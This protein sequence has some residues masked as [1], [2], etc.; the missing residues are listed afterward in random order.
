MKIWNFS[1]YAALA[2]FVIMV[3]VS[4]VWVDHHKK[5]AARLTIPPV[6]PAS[7]SA[8]GVGA[9]TLNVSRDLVP[10]P[11]AANGH[12]ADSAGFAVSNPAGGPQGAQTINVDGN[13][14]LYVNG[15]EAMTEAEWR[16]RYIID[17]VDKPTRLPAFFEICAK[18]GI[19]AS[20]CKSGFDF[21]GSHFTDSSLWYEGTMS[22]PDDMSLDSRECYAAVA[23][24]RYNIMGGAQGTT[25]ACLAKPE[26]DEITDAEVRAFARYAKL[27]NSVK[28]KTLLE[29][30]RALEVKRLA[31][32]LGAQ[33]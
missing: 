8:P 28:S 15:A 32:L 17:D 22:V 1:L 7:V 20:E 11:A 19:P 4:N 14:K 5:V 12:V 3:V 29:H 31:Q 6:D 23:I 21:D 9:G 16:K 33:P 13:Q 25:Y 10:V 27:S 2:F 24:E 30:R 26:D 18:L